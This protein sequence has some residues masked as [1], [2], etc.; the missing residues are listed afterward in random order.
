MAI[1]FVEVVF[2]GPHQKHVK[3]ITADGTVIG[4]FLLFFF[5]VTLEV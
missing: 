1:Q 4:Q 3:I 5:G 2:C